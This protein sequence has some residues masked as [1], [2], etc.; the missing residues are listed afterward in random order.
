MNR[1]ST[2]ITLYRLCL[3]IGLC[4]FASSVT[5]QETFTWDD[6]PLGFEK[7]WVEHPA[8]SIEGEFTLQW[9]HSDFNDSS[10]SSD[11]LYLEGGIGLALDFSP[12][13]SLGGTI[14]FEPEEEVEIGETRFFPS[15]GVFVEEINLSFE[16]DWFLF[17]GG[18]FSPAFGIAEDSGPGLYGGQIAE[19]YGLPEQWGLFTSMTIPGEW[20]GGR[21]R[22][23]A[24]LFTKDTTF[25][26]DSAIHSRGRTERSDGGPSNTGK[27]NSYQINY[28]LFEVT[29]FELPYANFHAAYRSAAPGDSESER[30]YGTS[31]GMSFPLV[32]RDSA[33]DTASGHFLE[34]QPMFEW[35][36]F[37][38]ADG[39]D[40]L[41]RDYVTAGFDVFYGDWDFSMGYALSDTEAQDDQPGENLTALS[42]SLSYALFGPNGAMGLGYANIDADDEPVEHRLG[43]FVSLEFAYLDRF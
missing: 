39:T 25:L 4:T 1:T 31:L 16:N 41:E 37:E 7:D 42:T 27:L 36:H 26:S 14:T 13:L 10:G 3:A 5:A 11:E 8:I 17:G 9:D 15:E 20:T 12:N 18:K 22:V 35:T 43:L 21:Q 23:S 34:I 29:A 2:R 28:D 24:S 40:D 19:E 6:D 32:L 33:M 30:E 38:N